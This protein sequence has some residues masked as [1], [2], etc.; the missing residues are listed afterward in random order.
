M[1][2]GTVGLLAGL[3]LLGATVLVPPPAGMSPGAWGVAG[4]VM[5][6]AAWWVSE[7]LPIPA[8]ALVPLVALPLL[9]LRPVDAA[10]APYADPVIFLFMGGFLLAAALER[11]GLH[12]R[13]AL[14]I[15]RLGGVSPTRLVGS[16]MAATA[17]MSMWVSNTATAA[18]ML[19]IA[20]SVLA[21]AREQG[22]R[23]ADGADP[24]LPVAL[25]LGLAYSASIGGMGTL[26][27][28]P[29]NALLAGFMSEVYG[30]PVGFA[31]WLAVAVPLVVVA[32]PLTWLVLTRFAYPV[33]TTPIAGGRAAVEQMLR[34][35][36][37]PSAAEWTVGVVTALTAAAWVTRPLLARVVD[38]LS[39]TGIAMGAALTLFVVSRAWPAER[40]PL[41]W[42]AAE[43]LPWGVLVLFGGGLSLAAAVQASGLAEW[44][45]EAM[46]AVGGWPPVFI[47][48]VVVTIIVFLTELTSNTATAAALLPVVGALAVAIGQPVL[49]LAVPTA[50]ASSCAFMMPVATP[51]NALVYGSGAVTLPQMMRAGLVLNV[52][53][54]VLVTLLAVGLVPVVLP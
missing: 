16:F 39:D 40:R 37:R 49:L 54:I 34:A 21:L 30:R 20:L 11:S 19:P 10:A 46:T 9:G 24:N 31:E 29:P 14:T 43:A 48:L 6:M 51:G 15:V 45:G 22:A 25:L 3:V 27:G 47:V 23:G 35:L 36:G 32:I 50:I 26:I 18:M 52:V 13:T 17:F 7:A 53:M 5:L 42:A 44:I 33:R 8:T 12:K 4:V 28:T 38:G 2:R 41:D 1:T